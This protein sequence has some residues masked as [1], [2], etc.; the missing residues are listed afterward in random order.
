MKRG[1]TQ[2]GPRE[3]Q[4]GAVDA[5]TGV[6]GSNRQPVEACSEASDEAGRGPKQGRYNNIASSKKQ[7]QEGEGRAPEP[8]L[9]N[10]RQLS[11]YL[12]MPVATL[13][14]MRCLGRIPSDCIVRFGRSLRFDRQAVD[15]WI[16]D[17]R[18]RR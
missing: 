14:T 18:A 12:A 13:Y 2:Q 7:A 4:K 10:I 11:D 15:R 1:D 3:G 5:W 9:L 16:G 8:R 6:H 17:Q